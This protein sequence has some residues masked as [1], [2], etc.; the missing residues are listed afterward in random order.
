L[1]TL[2]SILTKYGNFLA[3]RKHPAVKIKDCAIP[4]LKD[5]A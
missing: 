1:G 5:V 2:I 3:R 4:L